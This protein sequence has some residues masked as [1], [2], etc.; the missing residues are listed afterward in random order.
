MRATKD[1]EKFGY[2]YLAIALNI[3]VLLINF[4]FFFLFRH[5]K[6]FASN[7]K[8]WFLKELIPIFTTFIKKIN[9]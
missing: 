7:A 8:F 4:L 9:L 2:G 6:G 3:P 1:C 5:D